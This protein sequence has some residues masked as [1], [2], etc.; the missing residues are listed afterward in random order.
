MK[1]QQDET[2]MRARNMENTVYVCGTDLIGKSHWIQPGDSSLGEIVA[3]TGMAE[4][5][6]LADVHSEWI[7]LGTPLLL[8]SI[9]PRTDLYEKGSSFILQIKV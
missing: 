9:S 1:E 3:G 4:T 8:P 5:V 7:R 2:Y 6:L